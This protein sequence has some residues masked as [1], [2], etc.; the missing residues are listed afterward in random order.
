M[1]KPTTKEIE[2]EVHK[3]IDNPD[4]FFSM[5]YSQGVEYA[6]KWGLG[7]SNVSPMED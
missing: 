4:V 6:L 5:S 3:A 7:E 1:I 2:D